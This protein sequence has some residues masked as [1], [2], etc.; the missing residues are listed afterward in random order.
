MSVCGLFLVCCDGNCSQ[1]CVRAHARIGGGGLH[2]SGCALVAGGG[3]SGR[4]QVAD[5]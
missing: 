1:R 4:D 3:Q 5:G 2:G